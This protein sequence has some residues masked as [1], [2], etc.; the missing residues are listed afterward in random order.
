MAKSKIVW[1]NRA[2]KRLYG[3]LE[4]LIERNNSKTYSNKLHRLIFK[5]VKLLLK[6]PD[7]G[8]KTTEDSIRGLILENY[9]IYY[10]I[11]NENIM[12][13]TIWKI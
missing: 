11:I 12:I 6:H 2:K 3:I 7:L 4:L 13:Q 1:S 10:G 9:V 8:L 5:E